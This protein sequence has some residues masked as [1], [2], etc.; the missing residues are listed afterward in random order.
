MP[1][2]KTVEHKLEDTL[3]NDLSKTLDELEPLPK[4][5][6]DSLPEK[7]LP[8]RPTRSNGKHPNSRTK[9]RL[10]YT[11]FDVNKQ[12]E[13][14]RQL[15]MHGNLTTAASSVGIV[16]QTVYELMKRD[17]KFS[18]RVDIARAK[19]VGGLENEL[20]DRIFNGN[21]VKVYDGE[22]NLITE[23]VKHDNALL[24]KALEANDRERYG[25]TPSGGVTV[26]VDTTSN[27]ANKLSQLLGVDVN[28]ED[29]EGECKDITPDQ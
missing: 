13:F 9:N 2:K 10:K 29:F 8:K 1:K 7:T 22:G 25:K 17:P 15:S 16:R 5:V 27:V 3:D 14:L 12:R 24:L 26:N 21:K 11:M 23:T 28:R 18:A 19:A 20:Y 6:L 4:E